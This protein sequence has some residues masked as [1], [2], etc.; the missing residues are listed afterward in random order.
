MFLSTFMRKIGWMTRTPLT[1]LR[2]ADRWSSGL[3]KEKVLASFGHFHIMPNN[4][5]KYLYRNNA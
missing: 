1:N 3:R 2:R 5:Q 4:A